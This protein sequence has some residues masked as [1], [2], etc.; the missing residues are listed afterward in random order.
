MG[1]G[2][3]LP[4]RKKKFTLNIYLVALCAQLPNAYGIASLAHLMGW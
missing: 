2:K 3:T 4:K 1:T